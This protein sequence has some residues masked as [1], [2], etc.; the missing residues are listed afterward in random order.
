MSIIFRKSLDDIMYR[1]S[2][3][4][5][6]ADIVET[7]VAYRRTYVHMFCLWD[8]DKGMFNRLVQELSDPNAFDPDSKKKIT[9]GEK[10][11]VSDGAAGMHTLMRVSRGSGML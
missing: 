4:T 5:A 8:R 10:R 1:Y 3:C 7:G 11:G 2:L 6:T 9:T